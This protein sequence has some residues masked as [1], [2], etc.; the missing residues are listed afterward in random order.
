MT[1]EN[2]TNARGQGYLSSRARRSLADAWFYTAARTGM[3]PSTGFFAADELPGAS[4]TAGWGIRDTVAGEPP[5][6]ADDNGQKDKTSGDKNREVGSAELLTKDFPGVTELYVSSDLPKNFNILSRLPR[7]S[8][9]C[10]QSMSLCGRE[11]LR[12]A[13]ML[14]PTIF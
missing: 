1:R 13:G 9:Q 12:L 4:E 6:N 3:R 14:N 8:P 5:P 7:T 10:V 11:L 2:E